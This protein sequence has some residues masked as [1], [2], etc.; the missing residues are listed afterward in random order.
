MSKP[1][2]IFVYGTLRRDSGHAMSH[3][4]ASRA[5]WCGQSRV[6][7]RL[8][9][10]SY[11]PALVRGDGQV[12]GDLY[13]LENPELILPVLDSFEEISGQAQDEY[14]RR[15]CAVRS[16]N[17]ETVRAWVYEYRLPADTLERVSSG[18]WLQQK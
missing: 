8:Y 4:L 6:A 17:G 14:E 13:R 11:Y 15:L 2:F 16:G 5:H 12:R 10:V 9:R 18:D 3:W 7:G 1:A